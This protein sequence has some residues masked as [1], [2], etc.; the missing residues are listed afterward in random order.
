MTLSGETRPVDVLYLDNHLMVVSKPAGLLVQADATGDTDLL[1]LG[2][3]YIKE[4]FK[5]P[6][7]VFLALVHRLDRPVSGVMVM[8]RTSKSA[9]RLT[10][11]FRDRTVIKRYCAVVEGRM[12][13]DGVL[14]GYIRKQGGKAKM[15]SADY[16]KAAE[17]RLRWRSIAEIKGRTLVAIELETGRPHQIRLQL[18][19]AGH[20]ILGDRKHGSTTAWLGRTVALHCYAM[21]I[22]HPTRPEKMVWTQ[23]PELWPPDWHPHVDDLIQEVETTVASSAAEPAAGNTT[24]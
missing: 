11:Q 10:A 16:P 3:A 4:K 22:D 13:G 23:L 2:K 12:L 1:T 6:G 19:G 20:P 18:A 8:A 24:T 7:Q 17:A 5:K 15:V 21:A 14:D 9:S